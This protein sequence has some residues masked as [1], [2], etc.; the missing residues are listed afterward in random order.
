MEMAA[1]DVA[2]E[3]RREGE[4]GGERKGKLLDKKKKME[5]RERKENKLDIGEDRTSQ[6]TRRSQKIRTNCQS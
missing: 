2:A 3:P 5:V 1:A 4:R 6:G